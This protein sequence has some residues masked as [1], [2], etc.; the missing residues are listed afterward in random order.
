MQL[1][2]IRIALA[3]VALVAGAAALITTPWSSG[4]KP[5]PARTAVDP[6]AS[7]HLSKAQRRR[8]LAAT[9]AANNSAPRSEL[10]A[11]GENLFRSTA[12]AK[13]G[14]S[15]ETCHAE[16]GRDG[17]VGIINHPRNPTDFKGARTPLALWD[18]TQT[19]PYTWS[20]NTATLQTQ[21][22]NV[23]KTFFKAGATQSDQVTGQQ[24]ASLLAYLGTIKPPVTPFDLGTMSAAAL[25]GE[26]VFNGK[27]KCSHCHTGSLF[28][29]LQVHDTGVPKG[30][31]ETDPGNKTVPGAFDTPTLRDIK[32]AGPYMHN[33]S[34]PTLESVVDFYNNRTIGTDL[35]N[36][37]LSPQ[38]KAD[39]VEFMKAL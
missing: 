30:P 8:I 32:D 20:G 21:T 5:S 33:G 2:K 11:Q 23:I 16:G 17:T 37:S 26:N 18:V 19:A 25:R 27:G 6:H 36:G 34:L 1:R 13:T 35:L 28:T 39:L 15:C 10:I 3:L 29:D 7:V 31:G 22:V 38:E 14:E 24:A 4:S 9:E 12:V